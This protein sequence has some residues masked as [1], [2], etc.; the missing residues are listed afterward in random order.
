MRTI[1][2]IGGMSWES[3]A[4]Y[5]R[6]IN[7]EVRRRLGGMH[8]AR[9]VMV[10]VDFGEIAAL[11][12]AGDRPRLGDRIAQAA[13]AAQRGGAELLALCT[14]TM[15]CVADAITAVADVPLVNVMNVTAQAVMRAG[16][17][18]VGLLGTAFTME[19]PFYVERLRAHGLDV[20]VPDPADRG[21]VHDVIYRELV[22]GLVLDTSRASYRDVIAR[23]V[24]RGA[25]AVILG[26]TEIMLLVTAQ[27]SAVPLFDTTEL[28]ALATV[29]AALA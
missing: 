23:L 9:C 12:H 4:H 19:Q 8:S 7:Q 21:I 24:A 27:D 26:C 1:G 14:N 11:Q 28:H 22:Q 13:L 17:N 18:R 2:L 6:I 10:S 20:I 16:Y 25:E 5:Y 3:S 15:H 29:D